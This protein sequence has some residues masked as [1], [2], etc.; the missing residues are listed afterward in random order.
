MTKAQR[1]GIMVYLLAVKA[2]GS[3]NPETLVALATAAGFI[4]PSISKRQ[5]RAVEAY[6]L[7][8]IAG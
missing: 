1:E 6:L 7:C 4:S 3:T 5:L 8:Q 2:G